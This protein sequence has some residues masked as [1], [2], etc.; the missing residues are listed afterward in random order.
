MKIAI[1]IINTLFA[2]YGI[3]F[4]FVVFIIVEAYGKYF[5]FT[6]ST[7]L[8]PMFSKAILL[9]IAFSYIVFFTK[10]QSSF[11]LLVGLIIVF[12]IGQLTIYPSFSENSLNI[13]IKF[14]S[15]VIFFLFFNSIRLSKDFQKQTFTIFEWVM[16]ANSVLIVIGALIG[17]YFFQS[18]LGNR[19]GYSGVFQTPGVTSYVYLITMF[20][21]VISDKKEVY[22]NWKFLIIYIACFFVGTKSL[23]LGLIIITGYVVYIQNFK[24]K[25]IVLLSGLLFTIIVSYFFFFKFGLFNKIRES[26]GIL[27]AVLSY[28]DLLFINNT[29]PYIL[30][31]WTWIN[32]FFGGTSNYDLRAQMEIIDLFFFWGVFGGLLY[33]VT[34]IKTFVTFRLNNLFL[35]FASLL[36]IV[37]LLAGNFFVYSTITVFLL[38]VREKIISQQKYLP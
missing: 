32:Y 27:S 22:K 28:R 21:F 24:Y 16:V 8:I 33:L 9:V 11:W 31:N 3:L 19:F 38:I 14:F 37:I 6:K 10:K 20:Y 29:K 26:K 2:K 36:I 35:V 25:K 5:Y 17:V 23:Y 34:L 12:V 7:T 15:P 13:A 18:Y 1:N 4:L 30:E